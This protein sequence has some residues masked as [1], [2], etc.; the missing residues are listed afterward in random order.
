MLKTKQFSLD[1]QLRAS[2]CGLQCPQYSSAGTLPV[3]SWHV[4]V[5]TGN[6]LWIQDSPFTY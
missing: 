4:I 2:G 3:P 1:P 6:F 5:F